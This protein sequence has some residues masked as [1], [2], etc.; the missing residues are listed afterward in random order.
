MIAYVVGALV[1]AYALLGAGWSGR[2]PG[3]RQRERD[4][5]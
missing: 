3:P 5:D 4:R 1:V 2:I